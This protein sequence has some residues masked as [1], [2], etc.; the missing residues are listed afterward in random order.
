VDVR[1][2]LNS[3]TRSLL[4][5]ACLFVL[6][7]CAK[8]LVIDDAAYYYYARQ[9]AGHPLDPYGF[10]MLWWNR[11]LTANEVLAPP[12]FP[13]WWSLAIRLLGDSPLLWKLWL[14]PVS[15]LFVWALHD[16]FRRFAHGLEVPLTWMTVLSPAIL[17]GFHLMLDVPALAL[18]L[19]AVVVFLRACDRDSAALAA[20]AGLVAGVAAETKYTGFLAPAVML[21][22]ALLHGRLRL[23]PLAALLAVQVFVSWEFLTAL[24]YGQSHFLG[25]L[26][27]SQQT[28]LQKAGLWAALL[29][30]LGT[31]APPVLLLGLAALRAPRWLV[32]A[33]GV[34]ALSAYL[35]T[36]CVAWS[37]Q[38][39]YV[40]FVEDKNLPLEV[41]L[42]LPVFGGLGL[43]L[44]GVLAV[45]AWRLCRLPPWHFP[46]WRRWFLQ[47][48]SWFLVLWLGLEVAGFF[49]L[50][51]FPAVR[52]V[53]GVVVVATLLAGR[54][55]ARSGRAPGR[56]HL[57]H[58]IAGFSA[59]VGLAFAALDFWEGWTEKS[60]VE[61][62]A[63]CVRA[64]DPDGTVWFVGHWGFQFYAEHQGMRPVITYWVPYQGERDYVVLPEASHLKAGDWLVVPD[65]RV[66]QQV[67][68]ID[69]ERTEER[70]RL[71]VTDPVRLRTVICY[72]SGNTALTHCAEDTRLE[73][74]VYRVT[75]DFVAVYKR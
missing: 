28:L 37:W 2:L 39:A 31:V 74:T 4:L 25:A 34:L 72:Y 57:I 61:R 48:A 56:T 12:V 20:L 70:F 6:L 46:G 23:W 29:G 50:T 49:A 73:V 45:A 44:F 69:P 67:M 35:S 16:C 41:P 68:D 36:A 10:A 64:E 54:L 30:I 32:G 1:T 52:R 60:L 7:D 42:E 38:L 9:M 47:R 11:P 15:L 3:S 40:P 71:S 13:Y 62:A 59:A 5:L 75:A 58:G 51:P 33:G 24:L 53:L 63:A 65:W 21:L 22:Y 8:P 17:P 55:A 18:S 27:D 14:L 43:V 26:R 66:H 19:T